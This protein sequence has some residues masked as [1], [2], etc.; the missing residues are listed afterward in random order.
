MSDS[1]PLD[2]ASLL[3]TMVQLAIEAGAV[4]WDHYLRG[5]QVAHKADHSPVTAADHDSEA[6]ILAGLRQAF[7][8]LP[9]V[10][11]EQAAAGRIPD[12]SWAFLLVDPLDGTKEFVRRGTDFTVNIA[13]IEAAQPSL[14]VVYA[15]AGHAWQALQPPHQE[16]APGRA[17][18]VRTPPAALCAVASKSHNTPGTEAW[19]KAAGVSERVAIGS[20]LKF[21]LLASG[22]ADVY[23]RPAP[24]M[25][26]DTAAGDALLRAAGGHVYDPDGQPLRYGKP[27]FRNSGFVA[28]GPYLPAPLRPFLS[29]Q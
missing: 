15:Q 14:G 10:A 6:L 3:E 26:W 4:V 25:E 17:I 11:E 28:S 12:V 22:V 18:R 27:Q 5:V 9:V 24:T 1:R 20:S 19:L 29:A 8:Q 7:P 23:P 21:A 13:L 16:R 2:R